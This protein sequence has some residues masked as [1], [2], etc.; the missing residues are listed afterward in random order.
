MDAVIGIVAI[1]MGLAVT[2][3][4]AYRLLHTSD[5]IRRFRFDSEAAFNQAN[6]E[7]LQLQNMIEAIGQKVDDRRATEKDLLEKSKEMSTLLMPE[8]REKRPAIY[9]ANDRRGKGD[10]EYRATILSTRLGGEWERGRE[11][12]LWAK[13]DDHARRG[14]EGKFPPGSGYVVEDLRKSAKPL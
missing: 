13:D 5:A 6:A 14:F 9:V 7:I 1:L 11:Y 8:A 12:V 2:G 10:V 3:F 4:G